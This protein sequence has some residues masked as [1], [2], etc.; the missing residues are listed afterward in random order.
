M[1]TN[2][3]APRAEKVVIVGSG[4]AGYTA[5]LYAARANLDP[6]VIAGSQPGG[7]LT[8]TTDVEN[9]PGFPQGIQGPELMDNIREQALRFGTRTKSTYVTEVNGHESPYELVTDDGPIQTKTLIIAT[10]ASPRLLGLKNEMALMGHGVSACAT[11]DGFFFQNK[12]VAVV[13][14]GDSAMEEAIFL[15]KFASKVTVIHRRDR[16]RA[17]KFMADR[18]HKN[19]KIDFLFNRAIEEIHDPDEG[20][21]TRLTLRDTRSDSTESFPVDGLFLAIGHDPNT[22][23]F[24]TA[25]ELDDA[26]Y[27]LVDPGSTRTSKPGIFACGDC[28]DHVYRQAIT[29]AGSGCMAALD[30]ERWIE[31]QTE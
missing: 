18:A 10:G 3:R 7:Q 27:I 29:A 31:A 15:T 5:A 22:G 8:I 16:L 19:D 23:A 17:S 20:H 14:G 28:V 26:G 21:V 2:R 1:F 30:A 12:H 11:C 4:P 24:K 6:L 25:L 9:F 13:G